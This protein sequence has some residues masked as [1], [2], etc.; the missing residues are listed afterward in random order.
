MYK[1]M[2]SD[3]ASISIQEKHL[4]KEEA[5]AMR[6]QYEGCY[7]DQMWWIMPH[8]ESDYHQEPKRYSSNAVDGFEDM[9]NY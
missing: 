8:D 1:L 5:N 4:T 3:G 6:D 2:T 7:P 9:Y